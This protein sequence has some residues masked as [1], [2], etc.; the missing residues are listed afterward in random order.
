MEH[1]RGVNGILELLGEA[2]E[3]ALCGRCGAVVALAAGRD[4]QEEGEEK[5]LGHGWD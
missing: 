1:A 3:V 2:R 4:E 5:V